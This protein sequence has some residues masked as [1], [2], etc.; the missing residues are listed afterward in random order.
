MKKTNKLNNQIT[1]NLS[2]DYKQLI[3]AIAEYNKRK[4]A[5]LVRLLL[6]PVLI[7][8]YAKIMRAIHP[9]N[10]TPAEIAQYKKI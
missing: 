9:S 8:E 2:D 6:E 1:I 7:D 4:P 3:D 10:S 5:E